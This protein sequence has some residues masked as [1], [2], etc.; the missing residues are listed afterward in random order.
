RDPCVRCSRPRLLRLAPERSTSYDDRERE[1][2]QLRDG[3][4]EAG[5]TDNEGGRQIK[6]HRVGLLTSRRQRACAETFFNPVCC[7]M[8]HR[9]YFN[10]DSIFVRSAISTE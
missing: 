9:A 6:R 4:Y 1:C 7:K 3:A 10:N 2:A 5:S 8:L